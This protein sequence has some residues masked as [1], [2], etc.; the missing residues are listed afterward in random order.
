MALA[1]KS[2]VDNVI[3]LDR[4]RAVRR[5]QCAEMRM[6]EVNPFGMTLWVSGAM[7]SMLILGTIWAWKHV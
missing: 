5:R 6:W 4:A 2:K 1:T 7:W 3:Y